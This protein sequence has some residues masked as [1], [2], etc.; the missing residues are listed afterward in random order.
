MTRVSG[1]KNLEKTDQYLITELKLRG[2]KVVKEAN[3]D[4][5]S[6]TPLKPKEIL[7]IVPPAK[8]VYQCGSCGVTFA[9]QSENCPECGIALSW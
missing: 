4:K 7:K 9:E 8:T 5:I 3:E 6:Q 2:Y 1:A